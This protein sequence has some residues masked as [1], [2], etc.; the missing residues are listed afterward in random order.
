[1]PRTP[2]SP[3][4]ALHPGA[5]SLAGAFTDVPSAV[6]S[7]DAVG[8][9]AIKRKT[10]RRANTAERRATHNAVERQ[11]RETLNGRFLDLA[12]LL[13]NL[14]QIRRPSKS[15]IVN[16]SIAHVH[17]SK[18][19]RI[20]A[21]RELRHLKLEAD[22]YRREIN[23]WR[24]RA[25]LPGVEEP[26]R[27]DAFSLVMSGEIELEQEL[28]NFG[29]N[30]EGGPFLGQ[31]DEED[32]LEDEEEYM[33]GVQQQQQQQIPA[34]HHVSA[35][36]TPVHE[37]ANPFSGIQRQLQQTASRM[38]AVSSNAFSHG[39]DAAGIP[40]NAYDSR[41]NPH[42]HPSHFQQTAT[43]HYVNGTS[44]TT[45]DDQAWAQGMYA[46]SVGLPMGGKPMYTPVSAHAYGLVRQQSM[47][48]HIYGSPVDG[49]DGSVGSAPGTAH[50][51]PMGGR[52]RS[53]ST[54]AD[55]AASYESEYPIAQ[56]IPIPQGRTRGLSV[57]TGHGSL[58]VGSW[59][60][61]GSP[62]TMGPHGMPMKSSPVPIPS[63]SMNMSA[64][65][66]MGMMF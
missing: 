36:V 10:S 49:D 38:A 46:A 8:G 55:M 43:A 17:A 40:Y 6:S 5:P 47:M 15:A 62:M 37:G 33:Q 24:E 4:S 48:G 61:I 18:T 3:T 45:V 32:G 30:F 42:G 12:G 13:P 23:Q 31:V 27:S 59:D 25:G 20:L 51:I 60:G 21:A 22:A 44:V 16:S 58:P 65:A 54:A 56:G 53:S 57:S 7:A 29:E 34:Q 19:H 28:A 14:A 64:G 35:V 39:Y 41:L 26:A 9:A 50:G 52:P 63:A 2:E 11:R 66:A 1:M